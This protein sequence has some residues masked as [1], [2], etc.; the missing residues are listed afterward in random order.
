MYSEPARVQ[1]VF[2]VPTGLSIEL[3]CNTYNIRA[4]QTAALRVTKF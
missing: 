3:V 4:P 2:A 1:L